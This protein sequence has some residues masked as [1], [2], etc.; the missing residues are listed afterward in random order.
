[1]N[2]LAALLAALFGFGS[3]AAFDRERSPGSSALGCEPLGP[4]VDADVDGDG[5]LDT[6]SHAVVDGRPEVH[7]CV[8]GRDAVG[9][10]VGMANALM[11]TD[12]DGDGAEEVFA[13]H[14][15][16]LG[17]TWSVLRWDGRS[18]APVGLTL[19][20]GRGEQG[21]KPRLAW[22]CERPNRIVQLD[23][24]WGDRT[25]TRTVAT[26]EKDR[27]TR[28][29]E[30]EPLPPEAKDQYWFSTVT[31]QCKLHGRTS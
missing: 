18:L 5:T 3:C 15:T 30:T 26:F 1:M 2:A 25:V 14:Q 24:D 8:R 22:G 6:V 21:S 9:P 16:E 17:Q 28:V 31:T 7:A 23:V 27:V 4:V 19:R 11:F 13:G 10:G 29:V 20:N 12:V